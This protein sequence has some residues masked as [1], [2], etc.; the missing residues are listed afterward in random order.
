MGK[1]GGWWREKKRSYYNSHRGGEVTD[2]NSGD[3]SPWVGEGGGFWTRGTERGGPL[4]RKLY[5]KHDYRKKRKRARA[6]ERIEERKF[7]KK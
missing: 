4:P 3:L 1:L 6:E 2:L 5:H 7:K